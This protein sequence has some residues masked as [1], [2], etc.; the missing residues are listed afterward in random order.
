MS[1]LY[2]ACRQAL[3]EAWASGAGLVLPLGFFIGATMLVPFTVGSETETLSRLGPGLLWLALALS[4]FVTLERVFQADLQEGALELW[5]QESTPV[6]FIALVKTISHWL[7]SGLPLVLVTPLLALMLQIPAE[8]ILPAMITYMLG[9][10]TFF[11]W[12]GVAAALAASIARGGLLIALIAL[13]F[14]LPT[15]IFG[16]LCLQAGLS[17][18]SFL[19]L[20]AVML[21]SLGVTPPAMG[22]A[23][24]LAVD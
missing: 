13:P 4:S 3:A 9:G 6:S 12:G 18:P 1:P 10:L 14:Y 8:R 19:F 17:D 7:V 5:V 24:R 22:A 20:I 21:F 11:L 16:S 2:A 23:L 15:L